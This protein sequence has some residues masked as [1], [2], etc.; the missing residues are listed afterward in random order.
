VKVLFIILCTVSLVVGAIIFD[1]SQLT[2]QR[3]MFT[4]LDKW[5]EEDCVPMLDGNGYYMGET[6]SDEWTLA[7]QDDEGRQEVRVS[8]DVF[9]Q[10]GAGDRVT[11]SYNKG[12]LGLHHNEKWRKS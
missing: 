9:R 12:R 1:A 8:G 11:Q 7:V 4:L 5:H 6:C 3:N 2:P 10:F